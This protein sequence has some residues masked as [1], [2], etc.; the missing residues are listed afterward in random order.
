MSQFTALQRQQLEN[1]QA[2][3]TWDRLSRSQQLAFIAICREWLE[4]LAETLN[5]AAC[6]WFYV[7]GIDRADRAGF[8]SDSTQ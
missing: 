1:V 6:F 2:L 7:E 8:E 4:P 3:N 5:I